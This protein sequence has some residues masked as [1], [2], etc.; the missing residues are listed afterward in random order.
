[1]LTLKGER[2]TL[3]ACDDCDDRR[4]KRERE[5]EL[6]APARLPVELLLP[7][8]PRVSRTQRTRAASA[9]ERDFMA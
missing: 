2:K 5:K 3:L 6:T 4:S 7:L 8:A 9:G 1:M